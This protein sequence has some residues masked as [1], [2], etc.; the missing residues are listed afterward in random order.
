[1][2]ELKKLKYP[3]GQFEYP[4]GISENNISSWIAVLEELPERLTNLVKD[5]SN[6]QLETPYRNGGWTV[7][8]VI[9]HLADSHHHSY[10]LFKWALTENRPLIKAYEEKDWSDMIDAKIAPI[11]LSLNYLSALHAKLVYMLKSLSSEDFQKCYIHPYGSVN[12]SVA[13]N[14][15]KYAWHSNHHFAHIQNLAL[16]KGW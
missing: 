12:V 6:K 11:E 8:Q 15:G 14:L 16:R 13:E 1:M 4:V 2:E 7:R 10:T 3:I 9:H 5:F